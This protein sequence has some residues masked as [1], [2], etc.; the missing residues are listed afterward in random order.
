[1]EGPPAADDGSWF[2]ASDGDDGATQVVCH[3]DMDC[4][5]AACERLREPGLRGEPVVVGMGYE[6][7]ETHGAVAT[8]S[9]E[10]RT[11]GVE[12]AQAISTALEALPRKIEAATDP[13]L[14]V[15]DAGFYRPVDMDFY[16][17]VAAEVKALLHERAGTVREVSIDE[18]YLNASNVSWEGVEAFARDLKTDIEREVGVTASVGVAPTMSAAKVASDRDKPDGLVVV[19]PGE[20]REFFAPL[21]VE[22]VHGVGPVTASELR[23]MGVETAGDLAATD[24]DRLAD[25]FGE[26]GLAVRRYARGEDDRS[27]EPTGRPKS[28]SRESAFPEATAEPDRQRE[29]VRTL[30]AAVA[31]RAERKDVLYRTI[32]IKAVE[33][34]FEVNTRTESLPGPVADAD[35]VEETALSLFEEFAGDPVRKVGVRVSKLSFADRD[36]ASLD[37]YAEADADAGTGSGSEG[38]DESDSSASRSGQRSLWEF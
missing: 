11:Y 26:R 15:E 23:E 10:A 35:L 37:S 29:R 4:F 30:A 3:V 28:L 7:G 19:E 14:A 2:G 38:A 17:S 22:A 12:S 9:Y 32:G 25:R 31:A 27:V 18:A 13:D 1:M 33:P 8:A 34:P 20:V 6:P 16:E 21:D 24:P 5:Y 36:Q